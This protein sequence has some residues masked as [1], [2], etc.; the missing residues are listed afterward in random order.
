MVLCDIIE[1]FFPRSVSFTFH[2]RVCLSVMFLQNEK[3]FMSK[4]IFPKTLLMASVNKL[5]SLNRRIS[6]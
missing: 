4:G 3:L 5:M 6:V 2:S 1:I